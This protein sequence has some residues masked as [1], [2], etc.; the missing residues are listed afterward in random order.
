MNITHLR[1][2]VGCVEL[3]KTHRGP[4]SAIGV[5]ARRD[6]YATHPTWLFAIVLF[7][8]ASPAFA[9]E[10]PGSI[11]E[12]VGFDQRLGEQIPL[13]ARFRDEAGRSVALGEYFGKRPV[14]LTL[15]YYNCPLLCT[16]VLNGVARG[17]KPL[18]ISIGKDFDVVTLSIDPTEEPS[19]AAAK[20]AAYLGRYDRPGPESEA[21]WHFL[22]GETPAIEA[23]A[24]SVG[25][26]YTYN[27]RT[28]LYAH[29]AG[30]VILS[31]SGRI[32]RYFY[33]F[34]YS[35]KEIQFALK[36][37][38]TEKV[39]LPISRVLLLCYDYDAATGKYTLSILRV[40]R[41]A[42]IATALGVATFMAIM[43]WRERRESISEGVR[44]TPPGTTDLSTP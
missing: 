16:Q 17:L 6:E 31:P 7:I 1:T 36:E 44:A 26:R 23:L 34:D 19:L 28:K 5:P 22:T 29:A 15:A 27:P 39:G 35:P 4:A 42:A 10:T 12:R 38:A 21:G 9:Q 11:G 40:L 25:F 8:S 41:L 20:K 13:G 2:L 33:G 24:K 14:I 30:M 37:A 43:F 3:A 32:S 18:S